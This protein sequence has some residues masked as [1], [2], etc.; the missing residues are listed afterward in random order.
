M[1]VEI[2]PGS[3]GVVLVND[4]PHAIFGRSGARMVL[5]SADVEA[6]KAGA[7]RIV[8]VPFEHV[9]ESGVDPAVTVLEVVEELVPANG[10]RLRRW[11]AAPD[12]RI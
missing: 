7:N 11:E 2:A 3:G 4:V 5:A 8:V 10:W 12:D 1:L 6:F 9:A